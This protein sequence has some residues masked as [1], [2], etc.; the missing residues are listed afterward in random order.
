MA[1]AREFAGM[2]LR[3]DG[4]FVLQCEDGAT[5]RLELVRTPVDAVEKRVVVT[6]VA[7][8]LRIEARGVRLA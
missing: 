3:E 7:D 5:Y 2:L 4:A 1:E 8:G 6:G